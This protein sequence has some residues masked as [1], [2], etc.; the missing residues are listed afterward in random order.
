MQ[1]RSKGENRTHIHSWQPSP[2]QGFHRNFVTRKESRGLRV[3]TAHKHYSRC[4]KFQTV[5]YKLIAIQSSLSCSEELSP[6]IHRTK[7]CSRI[8]AYGP[9]RVREVPHI[10]QPLCGSLHLP[11]P[12]TEVC[13]MQTPQNGQ[14]MSLLI[15]EAIL[16]DA[17][18]RRSTNI[19]LY[20]SSEVTSTV[21]KVLVAMTL[22][23]SHGGWRAS[24]RAS[25]HHCCTPGFHN[26]WR[27]DRVRRGSN[28]L[29]KVLAKSW[30]FST[31]C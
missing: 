4:P 15:A 23:S 14:H 24:E 11:L 3:I 7:E 22:T 13:C 21:K 6:T 26:F 2:A 19:L 16:S 30:R 10:R 31:C 5:R 18:P 8:L 25:E 28:N 27:L 1:R 12:S 29:V 20:I 9:S 17:S